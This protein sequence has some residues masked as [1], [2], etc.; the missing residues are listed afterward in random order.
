VPL[1]LVLI[2]IVFSC[3]PGGAFRHDILD[4]HR[5]ELVTR[6]AEQR[7]CRRVRVTV[8]PVD[9]GDENRVGHSFK[10]AAVTC[11]DH[12]S[13]FTRRP[14]TRE[15]ALSGRVGIGPVDPERDDIGGRPQHREGRGREG[16]AGE[17]AHRAD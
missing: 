12:L 6:V 1:S 8:A 11:F 9:I 13:A 2:A 7:G 3:R 17:E 5:Q 10:E 4:P 14:L 15:E 16:M